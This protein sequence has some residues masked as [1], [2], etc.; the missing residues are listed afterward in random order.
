M[1]TATVEDLLRPLAPQVLGALVRRY[2]HFDLAEDATQE[3]LLAAAQQWPEKGTPDNT[4]GW[5]IRVAS[6]KLTDVLRSDEARRRREE[7][8]VALTPRD[9]FVAPP[10]GAARAPSRDDTVTLLILCC[11]PAL[12]SS[13]QIALTLRAVGGLTTAEIAHAFLVPQA[14]MAQRVSRAKQTIEADGARFERPQIDEFPERMRAV[15]QVLYLIFN[16]GYTVSSGMTLQRV[17]LT[18]EAI[19]LTRELRQLMPDKN[20]V[21]GLLALMLLVDAR[22]EA[23]T[24]PYGAI[25]PLLE[26]DRSKWD[27]TLI[28]EGTALLEQVLPKGAVGTYQLQAAIAA[29]HDEAARP[30]DTDWPQI[31]GLYQVLERISGGNPVVSLNR[32]VATG[33]VEGP[34]A[35]LDLLESVATDKRLV[36]SHR[37][38]ATRAFLLERA[39][40]VTAAAA[41]YREAADQAGTLP[42]QR[43]L[44]TKAA[45]L[46]RRG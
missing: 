34:K 20:E 39:G 40:D 16:E 37:V 43:F 18:S 22:R 12:S 17:D 28:A 44:T 19:R 4:R 6:R 9:A 21:A 2:G 30:E 11:H 29:V 8:V 41:A 24:T 1:S 15:M 42:E 5:L 35:G 45:A 7:T 3:A 23:R 27:Q 25:V 33:I 14:T 38:A 31:L 32:A 13:S 36:G 26:Q 46:D 10:P